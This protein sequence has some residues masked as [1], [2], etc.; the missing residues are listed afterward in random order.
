MILFFV[1][2][3]HRLP[4]V[5]VIAIF[6]ACGIVALLRSLTGRRYRVAAASLI[7][8]AVVALVSNRHVPAPSD[9]VNFLFG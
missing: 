5:P 4:I 2:A 1:S 9:G 8:V 7:L 3:R 6:A